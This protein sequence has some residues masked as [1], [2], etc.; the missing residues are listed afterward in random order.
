VLGQGWMNCANNNQNDTINK[1]WLDQAVR[2]HTFNFVPIMKLC[3]KTKLICFVF[4]LLFSCKD[5]KTIDMRL[6]ELDLRITT[7]EQK[8]RTSPANFNELVILK[9]EISSYDL[10]KEVFELRFG[11]LDSQQLRSMGLLKRRYQTLM[12]SFSYDK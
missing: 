12:K 8:L 11:K 7:W 5:L 9:G 10:D 4:G 6:N 2:K 1:R 3:I